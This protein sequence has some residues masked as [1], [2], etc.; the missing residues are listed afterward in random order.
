MSSEVI[1]FDTRAISN[2]R[3]VML[4]F[5]EVARH[6]WERVVAH[7]SEQWRFELWDAF[8][9]TSPTPNRI[10][11]EA[12]GRN[13]RVKRE[14]DAIT[15][16][17]GGISQVA[18]VAAERL[19]GGH[20]SELFRVEVNANGVYVKPIRFAMKRTKVLIGGRSGRRFSDSARRASQVDDIEGLAQIVKHDPTIKVLNKRAVGVAIELGLRS[21]AAKGGTM[22]FQWLGSNY[23]KRASSVKKSGPQVIRSGKGIPLGMVEFSGEGDELNSVLSG[24]VPGTAKQAS[25]HGI[26]GKVI[27]VR[28]AD[29]QKFIANEIERAKQEALSA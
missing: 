6:S 9:A 18:S 4:R 25:R 11:A 1:F 12:K 15:P 20:K 16:T 13:F 29:R 26:I 2:L 27:G 17:R 14:P 7:E 21:R 24:F 10:Y 22:G 23:K 19:M 28:I 8:R 5:A 3:R